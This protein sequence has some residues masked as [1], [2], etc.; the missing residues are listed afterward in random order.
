M[1]VWGG[2]R[3]AKCLGGVSSDR[4]QG[5]GE[6]SQAREAA[7]GLQHYLWWGLPAGRGRELPPAIP[8]SRGT[9]THAGNSEL[10]V[11]RT[12]A[13]PTFPPAPCEARGCTDPGR[14]S[15]SLSGL[16]PGSFLTL[17]EDHVL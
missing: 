5:L 11:E 1:A 15:V 3:D 16:N 9:R 2:D 4:G 6:P 10:R 8:P 12:Q 14:E 7:R 17:M 13:D